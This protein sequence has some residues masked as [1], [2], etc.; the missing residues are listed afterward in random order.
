MPSKMENEILER[1][2]R[3]GQ[4]YRMTGDQG[5]DKKC[6]PVSK[7][8]CILTRFPCFH[9]L[10]TFPSRYGVG[11]TGRCLRKEKVVLRKDVVPTMKNTINFTFIVM[12]IAV[13]P[14]NK[15]KPF[16]SS[17]LPTSSTSLIPVM[18]NN[19]LSFILDKCLKRLHPLREGCWKHKKCPCE[20]VQSANK[21]EENGV[22]QS[23]AGRAGRVR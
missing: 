7:S 11:L 5:D 20:N 3:C 2:E 16:A 22:L 9:P 17:S 12:N 15:Q 6:F 18:S 13:A 10:G 4:D 21:T 8:R 23:T 19:L 1:Y 14:K